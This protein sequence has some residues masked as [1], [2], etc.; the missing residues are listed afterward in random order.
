MTG[1]K[2]PAAVLGASAVVA[3][4]KAPH[5]TSLGAAVAQKT[6]PFTGIALSIYLAIALGL[7]LTGVAL[8]TVG[9]SRA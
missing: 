2:A 6:L 3:H 1:V 5:L 4:T 9:K 8:R 7:V